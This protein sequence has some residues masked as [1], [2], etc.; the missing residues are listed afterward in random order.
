MWQALGAW[1][2]GIVTKDALQWLYNLIV[3]LVSNV[4]A[5]WKADK[6]IDQDTGAAQTGDLPGRLSGGKDVEGDF[7]SNA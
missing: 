7:N 5:K 6:K 1:L 4:I 3:K 2:V